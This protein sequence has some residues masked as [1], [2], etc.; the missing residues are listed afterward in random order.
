MEEVIHPVVHLT[1]FTIICLTLCQLVIVMRER[2]INTTRV[3][4]HI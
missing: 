4:I 3:N 2:K 1:M